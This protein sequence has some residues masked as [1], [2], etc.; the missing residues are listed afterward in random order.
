MQVSIKVLDIG[1]ADAIIVTLVKGEHKLLFLIDGG[2]KHHSKVVI[3]ELEASLVAAGKANI[4]FI[5]CTH[6]DDDHIGGLTEI[7][8]VYS[9][10]TGKIWIHK[11]SENYDRKVLAR[12][13]ISKKQSD[14][15]FPSESD[16]YL[17]AGNESA[18]GYYQ[19]AIKNLQQE[20]NFLQLVK[21]LKIPIE[22]PIAEYF[23]IDGWPEL[24]IPGPTLAFYKSM[25]PTTFKTEDII[26]LE[27]EIIGQTEINAVSEKTTNP[28]AA[29]D[30]LKKECVNSN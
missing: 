29:L 7:V 15:I 12:K 21:D 26:K 2:R 14:G 13:I 23:N 9:E 11:T 5:I 16:N 25:F 1:D 30:N 17:Q 28:E 6:Y 24:S 19:E 3:P 22:E 8:K 27:A 18:V 10:K 4:D 20:I